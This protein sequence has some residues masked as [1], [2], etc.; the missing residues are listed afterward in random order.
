MKL[1]GAPHAYLLG[2]MDPHLTNLL[3]EFSIQYF[4]LNNVYRMP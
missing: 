4:P 1:L 3:T 2:M